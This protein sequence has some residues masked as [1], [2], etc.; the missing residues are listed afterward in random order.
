MKSFRFVSPALILVL[1]LGCTT[2]PEPPEPRP[3]VYPSSE[4]PESTIQR[5]VM[6]Y[7]AKN[8]TEYARLFTGDFL[9][10]FSNSADPDLANEY[11]TGWFRAD[12]QAAA[13][14]LFHGGVNNDGVIQP[15]AEDIDLDLVQMV[16][17]DDNG[18]GRDPVVHKVLFTPVVLTVQLPP[19]P[20]EPEGLTFVV[21][22]ADPAR[23]RFFLVRGDH[24]L[25]L[26]EDQPADDRHWYIRLWRD[27]STVSSS[28]SSPW[29]EG[30]DLPVQT[31]ESTWGQV[32][33]VYR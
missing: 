23:H 12:E 14:N 15:A 1:M 18:D 3:I 5:F 21:G 28:A 16:P 19:S 2:E 4:T 29:S 27:E 17:Q 30:A 7:E 6:L 22:G 33:A 31:E 26:A 9:F 24:A 10:E 20:Q 8:H 32:K 11:S 13:A 25:G